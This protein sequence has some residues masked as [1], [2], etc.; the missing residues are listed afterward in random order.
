LSDEHGDSLRSGLTDKKGLVK[1]AR[2]LPISH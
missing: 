1:N 2:A